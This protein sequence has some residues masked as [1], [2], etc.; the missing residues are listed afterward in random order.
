MKSPS[1]CIKR[2]RSSSLSKRLI[3]ILN[4]FITRLHLLIFFRQ[5]TGGLADIVVRHCR[6]LLSIDELSPSRKRIYDEE[7]TDELKN[8]RNDETKGAQQEDAEIEK[9]ADVLNE[10]GA[11][12]VVFD[13]IEH[14]GNLEDAIADVMLKNMEYRAELSWRLVRFSFSL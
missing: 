11:L 4:Y 6:K 12:I 2:I 13:T 1:R 14:S 7:C 5:D 3:K 8:L 9:C 10:M